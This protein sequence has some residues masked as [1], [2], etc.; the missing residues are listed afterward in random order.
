MTF[1]HTEDSKD[2]IRHGV[3]K[4]HQKAVVERGQYISDK[5]IE[6]IRSKLIN[7]MTEDRRRQ[8]ADETK[9]ARSKANQVRK[10][11]ADTFAL[12]FRSI[13][14]QMQQ[15]GMG[16]SEIAKNLNASGHVARRGGAWTDQTVRQ[17]LK[18]TQK[19]TSRGVSSEVI[20]NLHTDRRVIG[21]RH[22]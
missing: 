16:L 2:R 10:R 13:I 18:R 14:M 7:R 11:L 17:V 19:P 15:D 1:R 20:E 4:A 22:D 8:L 21:W 6:S 12:K 3:A 5:G 9:E